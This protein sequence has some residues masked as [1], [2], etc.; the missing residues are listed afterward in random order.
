MLNWLARSSGSIAAARS[1]EQASA[2]CYDVTPSV[3]AEHGGKGWVYTLTEVV[4]MLREAGVTEDQLN[5]LLVENPKRMF[6]V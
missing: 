4:P 6:A 1:R 5:D 2:R 3:F